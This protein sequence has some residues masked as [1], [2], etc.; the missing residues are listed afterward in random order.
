MVLSGAARHTSL[1][2]LLQ[3]GLR[4][5]AA[6]WSLPEKDLLM[7]ESFLLTVI[8]PPIVFGA[9]SL[10]A[11]YYS[12]DLGSPTVFSLG[13]LLFGS[14]L[15]GGWPWDLAL[16]LFADLNRGRPCA[17]GMGFIP[18]R[19]KNPQLLIA[20]RIV[21][22]AEPEVVVT[23][24]FDDSGVGFVE[25]TRAVFGSAADVRGP[26]PA[27]LAPNR[28]RWMPDYIRMELDEFGIPICPA[29]HVTSLVERRHVWQKLVK[30]DAVT[31]AI[32]MGQLCYLR[33]CWRIT[34][35]YL[36]NHKSWEVDA[37][38]AQ[39]GKKM[40]AY[41]FQ[42]AA[43]MI[44]P[45]QLV[46][47]IVEPKGAVP[48][49]GK[50]QFRDISD[51]REGNKSIPKWGT[52]LFTVRD[53]AFTLMWRAILFGFDISDGYHISVLAGCTGKLVSGLCASYRGRRRRV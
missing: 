18:E 27:W 31:R 12:D 26:V 24:F 5:L 11:L 30:M 2:E 46:P 47:S 9:V 1:V 35:S 10:P 52:R 49:K 33:T 22:V 48:K 25:C 32:V 51:A 13:T 34:P 21:S 50:D 28:T 39:L 14:A 36:P 8:G 17:G 23:V 29:V 6:S 53:L 20:G 38:K 44:L 37:V 19:G 16:R 41:F 3:G 4:C 42:G 7:A 45:G 15:A 43:E 40:A